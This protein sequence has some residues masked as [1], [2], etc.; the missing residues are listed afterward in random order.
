MILNFTIIPVFRRDLVAAAR[1]RE[2][3]RLHW[4]RSSF[5]GMLAAIVLGTFGARFYWSDGYVTHRTMTRA[6]NEAAGWCALV[7]FAIFNSILVRG[8]WSITKER[9]RRT[10]EFLLATPMTNAEIVLGKL[11]SC[12]VMVCTTMAAGLPV[13]LLLHVLG[14]IDLR[15]IA[16]CYASAASSILFLTSLAIWISADAPDIRL[17]YAA[18]VLGTLAWV[19]G[20]FSVWVFLPR[21]GIRMPE[22]VAATNR[23]LVLSSPISVAFLLATGLNSWVQL[24]YVVGRM[25]TLQLLGVVCL[26][27][28]AI[29]RLRSAHRTIVSGDRRARGLQGRGPVWRFRRRPPVGDDPILWRE[30]YTTRGNGLLK[31]V[32]VLGNL[33]LLAALAYATYYFARPAMVEVWRHGYGSGATSN[34]RPEFNLF[35]RMFVPGRGLNQPSDLARTEFNLFLRYVTFSITLLL[36][37]ISALSATEI[38]TLERKKET[39][40]S[41][42]A[43]P[44]TARSI[45]QSALLAALWRIRQP[46]AILGVLWTMGLLAGAIHPL[47]YLLVMLNVAAS[48]W[49]FTV[50]GLRASVRAQDQAAAAGYSFSLT[51]LTLLFLA[52]PLLLPA[53][54]NSVLLGA[55]SHLFVGWMSLV[56]YRDVRAALHYAVYPPLEWMGIGTGEGPLWALATCFLGIVAPAVG[57][58]WAWRHAIA[59]FDRLVGRAWR[60]E[61]AADQASRLKSLLTPKPGPPW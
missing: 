32:G 29:A 41:L 31:A 57:G 2:G 45:L 51:F 13:V 4:E 26:T 49:F 20:P 44:M 46:I 9:D 15:L 58:W 5:A 37:F 19:V 55:G 54:F 22:W 61:A 60:A 16:L 50:W 52:L 6:V 12:L 11:A 3:R 25:I 30:M 14:G 24:G 47:G 35:V 36:T 39:W 40:N 59:H 1:Q 33:G 10:L 43:T 8:A 42:L 56:S 28:A 34:A 27:I 48:V 7:H 53:R 38:I 17:A 23:W 18:F 21:F